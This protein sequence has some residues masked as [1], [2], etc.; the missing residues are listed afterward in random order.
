VAQQN[1]NIGFEQ[2]QRLL[3]IISNPHADILVQ[4]NAIAYNISL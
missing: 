3:N 1:K 2:E 4:I